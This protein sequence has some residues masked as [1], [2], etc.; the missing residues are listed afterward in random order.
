[1]PK[2]RCESTTRFPSCPAAGD[3]RLDREEQRRAND[4]KVR[5]HLVFQAPP[6]TISAHDLRQRSAATDARTA[7]ACA[8]TRREWMR[9]SGPA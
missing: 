7:A 9:W 1:M 8:A 2:V 3:L 4:K 5:K 6:P